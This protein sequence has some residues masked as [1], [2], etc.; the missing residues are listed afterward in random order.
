MDAIFDDLSSALR[1]PHS[2]VWGKVRAMVLDAAGK[3]FTGIAIGIG[4]AIGMAIAG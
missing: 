4:F 2:D 1:K 3:F